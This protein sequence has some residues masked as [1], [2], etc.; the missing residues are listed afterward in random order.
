MT[1]TTNAQVTPVGT[2]IFNAYI[3]NGSGAVAS[4]NAAAQWSAATPT[5]G[6]LVFTAGANGSRIISLIASSD[7]TAAVVVGLWR[8]DLTNSYL[9]WAQNVPIAAGG[10]T[11]VANVDLMASP[12]V[13]LPLD[14]SDKPIWYLN[15]GEKLYAGAFTTA[16]AASKSVV[17]NGIC[18]DY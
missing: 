15:A 11:Q 14:A 13:G 16:V 1:V 3:V 9:L 18:E 2:R 7:N 8:Y 6:V 4:T 5:N 10:I 12:I 17:I